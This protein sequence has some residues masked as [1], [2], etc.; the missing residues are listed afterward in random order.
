MKQYIEDKFNGKEVDNETLVKEL[1]NAINIY[2]ADQIQKTKQNWIKIGFIGEDRSGKLSPPTN[3]NLGRNN[4]EIEDSIA[5]FVYND[6]FAAINILEIT[7][8]DPAL[9]KDAEDIQKRLAQL[10][11]PGIRPDVQAFDRF[12][13]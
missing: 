13:G 4:K 8:S 1:K 7:I 12:S 10:H 5:E 3:V 9:Y 11:A 2:F 6:T